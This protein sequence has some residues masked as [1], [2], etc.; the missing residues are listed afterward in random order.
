[1]HC[2]R[3]ENVQDQR[4]LLTVA[5]CVKEN[6]EKEEW[7]AEVDMVISRQTKRVGDVMM[8]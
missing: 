1:M 5:A 7:D 6:L 8:R 3:T 4:W 2:T